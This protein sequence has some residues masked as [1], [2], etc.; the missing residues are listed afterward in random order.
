MTPEAKVKH[1]VKTILKKYNCYYFSPATGGY[2]ASGVPDLIVC[3]G[4]KFIGIECKAGSN[5][6]TQLQELNL[7]KIKE[8]GG[9]A[10]VINENNIEELN[11]LLKGLENEIQQ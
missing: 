3:Y 11:E 10:M 8:H 2:G 9:I 7:K 6:P 1:K 5:K 4:G